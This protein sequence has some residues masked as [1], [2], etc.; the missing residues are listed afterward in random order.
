MVYVYGNT[1]AWGFFLHVFLLISSTL[2]PTVRP[3]SIIAEDGAQ[4]VVTL[5]RSFTLPCYAMG[6]PRPSVIWWRGDK[7]LPFSM[8]PYTQERDFSLTI[9]PVELKTLGSYTC[10]A[11]NGRGRAAS[12]TVTLLAQGPVN[13]DDPIDINYFQYLKNKPGDQN[14][15]G[16]SSATVLVPHEEEA[17]TTTTMRSVDVVGPSRVTERRRGYTGR[18]RI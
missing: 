13:S 9:N 12:W 15:R 6:W 1:F 3:A 11:Y 17:T 2:D 18:L 4:Y 14:A 10:H 8:K 7:T 5:G 16:V